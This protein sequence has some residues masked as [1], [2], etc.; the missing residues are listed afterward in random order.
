MESDSSAA[1]PSLPLATI[2]RGNYTF[3]GI[4][5]FLNNMIGTFFHISHVLRKG[6]ILADKAGELSLGCSN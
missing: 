5:N 2:L 3:Y 4:T 1:V 6:N